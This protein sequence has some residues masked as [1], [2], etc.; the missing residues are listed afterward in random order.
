MLNK[1]DTILAREFSEALEDCDIKVTDSDLPKL[2]SMFYEE[3][4]IIDKGRNNETEGEAFELVA[5]W[6][7]D[8]FNENGKHIDWNYGN[9]NTNDTNNT[10]TLDYGK[11]YSNKTVLIRLLIPDLKRRNSIHNFWNNFC[12]ID[13][14]FTLNNVN[15]EFSKEVTKSKKLEVEW[16]R[17]RFKN[18]SWNFG[19]ENLIYCLKSVITHEQFI[20]VCFD[21]DDL[22]VTNSFEEDF[23]KFE[24]QFRN[25]QEILLQMRGVNK[26]WLKIRPETN[27]K[28]EY[29]YFYPMPG[30]DPGLVDTP[31]KNDNEWLS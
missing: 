2:V 22:D 30:S 20:Y 6:A 26:I 9:V 13:N 23:Y 14:D 10:L 28:T 27:T 21:I 11:K 4:K 19:P 29:T 16:C 3:L 12:R 15:E 7:N 8:S 18:N 5:L 31:L 1:K 24:K 17:Y 25:I